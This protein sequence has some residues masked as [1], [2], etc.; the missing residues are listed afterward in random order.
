MGNL[1]NT[2]GKSLVFQKRKV[3]TR[4]LQRTLRL[5][6]HVAV[7]IST[8]GCLYFNTCMFLF[9]QVVFLFQQ[10][11]F[12]YVST[13]L[14]VQIDCHRVVCSGIVLVQYLET[15]SARRTNQRMK[16]DIEDFAVQHLRELVND[17][18]NLVNE[19]DCSLRNA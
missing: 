2:V 12:P 10:T 3:V 7:S 8:C 4:V 5:F 6:Q 15:S 9:Q 19:R 17:R 11:D 13:L 16:S 14:N 1:T 18:Y